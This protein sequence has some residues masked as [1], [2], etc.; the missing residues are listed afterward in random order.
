M[1]LFGGGQQAATQSSFFNTQQQQSAPSLFGASPS[2]Q[3]APSIFGGAQQSSASFFGTN[4]QQPATATSGTGLFG[5]APAASSPSLFGSAPSLFGGGV[6]G[7]AF[8]SAHGQQQQQQPATTASLFGTPA[9]NGG[10][11]FGQQQQPQQ[12]QP[13][14]QQA[15][16]SLFGNFGGS[17]NSF[18]GGSNQQQQQQQQQQQNQHQNVDYPGHTK[19]NDLPE[20]YKQDLFAVERHLRDQ[21]AKYNILWSKR[22]SFDDVLTI[23]VR[24]QCE[25][26][27]HAI[28]KAR[29]E[30]DTMHANASSL[31]TAVATERSSAEPVLVALDN[32]R[33]SFGTTHSDLF[34][35]NG[36]NNT[37]G[38]GTGMVKVPDEY[39]QRVVDEL[40]HRAHSY[41]IEI[42]EIADFLRAQG[43]P[44]GGG[45]T[46]NSN[47]MY[48]GNGSVNSNGLSGNKSRSGQR[49]H[50]VM[51]LDNIS[52]RYSNLGNMN[53]QMNGNKGRGSGNNNNS[54]NNNGIES[55]GKTIEDIIKRQYDY[56]MLVASHIATVNDHLKIVKDQY[57]QTLRSRDSDAPNPFEQADR[58]EKA[59]KDRQRILAERNDNND[60]IQQ[61]PNNNNFTNGTG[62]QQ[63]QAQGIAQAAQDGQGGQG[64][65][66][67]VSNLFNS[68]GGFGVGNGGVGNANVRG[69]GV[70][71]APPTPAGQSNVVL[72]TGALAPSDNGI[73]N[74]RS[75]AAD[76]SDNGRPSA[77]RRRKW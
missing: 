24:K 32:L 68:G 13:Q 62:S 69:N 7:S 45:N 17:N 59:D 2:Q 37:F 33:R 18:M 48:N 26:V 38:G 6:G 20:N 36:D 8:F 15:A 19:I 46:H 53:H 42:D 50:G 23:D 61:Q 12:Q 35:S 22:E 3:S 5:A 72:T 28:V 16:G 10:S 41:K 40:V 11:I 14:Q 60:P 75:F 66:Q 71:T 49:V 29:A 65:Q 9:A 44:I 54:N 31:R 77:T 63:V 55:C 30:I 57:L 70:G 73:G 39:F 47:G 51:L 21:R 43:I 64:G 25:D 34:N 56:F 74:S 4:T 1:S 76:E 27:I 58:R 67:Q 52:Q